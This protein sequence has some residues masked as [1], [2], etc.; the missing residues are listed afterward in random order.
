MKKKSTAAYNRNRKLNWENIAC[1]TIIRN[2]MNHLYKNSL[3]VL[4]CY[5]PR[6]NPLRKKQFAP[7]TFENIHW[8][9]Q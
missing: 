6:E 2:K 9:V 7:M 3:D 5:N 1:G 4:K 8:F